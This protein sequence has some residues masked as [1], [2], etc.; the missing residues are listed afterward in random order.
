MATIENAW[1]PPAVTI[2][3]SIVNAVKE[4]QGTRGGEDMDDALVG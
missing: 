1:L 4:S 2:T 3:C